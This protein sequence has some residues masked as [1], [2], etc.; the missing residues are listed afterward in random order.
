MGEQTAGDP[1]GRPLSARLVYG[2]P[3]C[4]YP[5]LT[6]PLVHYHLR[7]AGELVPHEYVD[8]CGAQVS[9]FYDR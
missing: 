6:M 1:C 2:R 8:D 7:S 4:V 5:D 3:I 9:S